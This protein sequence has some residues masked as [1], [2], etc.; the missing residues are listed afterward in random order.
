MSDRPEV[1]GQGLPVVLS[2]ACIEMLGAANWSLLMY[3]GLTHGA[4]HLLQSSGPR[5]FSSFTC[6][7]F[8]QATGPGPCALRNRRRK[9]RWKSEDQGARQPDGTFKIS[10]RKIFIS[11][12][13]HDLTENII[14]VVLARIDGAPE[15]RR[16]IS[17]FLVP[18]LRLNETGELVDN[19]VACVGI[20]H[21]MGIHGSATCA[22]TSVRTGDAR[23]T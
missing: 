3:S 13:M 21:K 5:S 17:I 22:S 1:G 6:Q 18:R 4:A 23:V 8:S 14:H 10:G 7:S 19:D 15:G 16:G 12:G 2:F 11:S 20:E 9:R